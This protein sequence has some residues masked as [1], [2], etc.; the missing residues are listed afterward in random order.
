V[1]N[2]TRILDAKTVIENTE[3]IFALAEKFSDVF[4]VKLEMVDIGGGIGIPYFDGEQEFNVNDL[5]ILIAPVVN[6][7]REKNLLTRIILESGRYLVGKSGTMVS[8][9]IDV[10]Q[11]KGENFVITDGGTNCHMAAV[12]IGSLIKKNFPISIIK[13]SQEKV[14]DKKRYNITGP[15]CTPNDLIGKQVLL[16]EVQ[17]GDL[18][19]ISNSGAYGPT[20][21]PVMFLSH[22]FPNEILYKNEKSELIRRAFTDVDFFDGQIIP[23][24]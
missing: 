19:T 13:K 21:S 14:R 8:K 23:G 5:E 10:K 2:G 18:I 1:Y 17:V 15:L 20:A 16:P 22:G 7:F 11:S 6:G 4:G 9:V 24:E 3:Y 12:G